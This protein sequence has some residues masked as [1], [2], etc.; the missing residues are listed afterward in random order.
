[1]LPTEAELDYHMDGQRDLL[2]GTRASGDP[3]V[4]WFG[5]RIAERGEAGFWAWYREESRRGL[6][7]GALQQHVIAAESDGIVYRQL[8]WVEFQREFV[9]RLDVRIHERSM[10]S[11]DDFERAREHARAGLDEQLA[12]AADAAGTT[13]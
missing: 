6:A 12:R 11:C 8:A 4:D 2:A 10:V 5:S 7:R 13:S 3:A 9:D 1:L